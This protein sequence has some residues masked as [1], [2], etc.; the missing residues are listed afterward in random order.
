MKLSEFAL[1]ALKN[2]STINDGIVLRPGSVIKTV[3]EEET[4]WAQA[5]I[6]D[7]FPVEFG[8]YD[9]NN[10]LGNIAALSNPELTFEDNT[11]R[12][13]DGT[14]TLLYRGRVTSLIKAPPKGAALK[15]DDPDI[16][17]DLSKD[18]LLKLLKLSAM[19]GL[20]FVTLI[21]DDTNE[22]LRLQ[23]HERNNP[24]SN[25][26][27]I[28]LGKHEGAPFTASFKV[29]NL[30]ILPDDYVVELKNGAFA[31]FSSK[32]RKLTYFISQEVNKGKNNG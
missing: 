14:F 6:D 19:N 29:D 9:L 12:L 16:V 3:N 20:S 21:G 18:I 7:V 26:A 24:D 32:T 22:E 25:M 15:L 4:I 8:I 28:P 2:F 1:V 27:F 10:F 31:K 17:F 30:K 5:E 13:S 11:V 23:T